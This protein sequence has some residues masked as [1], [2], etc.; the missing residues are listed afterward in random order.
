MADPLPAGTVLLVEDEPE[1]R[2]FIVN[3]LAARG[4]VVLEAHDGEQALA[5]CRQCPDPIHLLITDVIIPDTSG[6]AL[7]ANV[8]AL[9][10]QVRLLYMSAFDAGVLKQSFGLSAK[11]LFLPK[12][13]SA[14]ALLQKVRDVLRD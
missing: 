13:F 9:R 4:Y 1:I 11:A 14:E 2:R 5:L 3:V 6:P 7:A 12:P 10:P 8:L